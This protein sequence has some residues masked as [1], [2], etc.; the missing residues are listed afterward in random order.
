MEQLELLEQQLELLEQQ[1]ELLEQVE[2]LEQV[3][4]LEQLLEPPVQVAGLLV[5]LGVDQNK[6]I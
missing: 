6:G 4:L 2:V 5:H 3:E 1:L